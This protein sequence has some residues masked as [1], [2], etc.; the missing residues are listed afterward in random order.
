M[1]TQTPREQTVHVSSYKYDFIA[2]VTFELNFNILGIIMTRVLVIH[3][4]T[5]NYVYHCE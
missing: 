3:H 5:G 1:P 2:V 4:K